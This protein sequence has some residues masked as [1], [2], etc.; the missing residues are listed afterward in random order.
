MRKKKRKWPENMSQEYR[1]ISWILGMICTIRYKC[2]I[3]RLI[4]FQLFV[5]FWYLTDHGTFLVHP[6]LNQ[7]SPIEKEG[8]G[9]YSISEGTLT[10]W[11]DSFLDILKQPGYLI[12]WPFSEFTNIGADLGFYGRIIEYLQHFIITGELYYPHIIFPSLL[13]EPL[14]L[15]FNFSKA[16]L[17]VFKEFMTFSSNY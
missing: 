10:L 6:I 14:M 7:I 15:F 13:L 2:V 5:V 8:K 1:I 4:C 9:C 3:H 11:D 12:D 16:V 17:S